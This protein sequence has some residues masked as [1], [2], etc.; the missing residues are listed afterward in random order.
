MNNVTYKNQTSNKALVEVASRKTWDALRCPRKLH[1]HLGRES[2][3][4]R[5][6][7]THPV[8]SYKQM[9]KKRRKVMG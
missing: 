2:E 1:Y 5:L 8:E 7:E 3:A 6:L 4:Q 9:K